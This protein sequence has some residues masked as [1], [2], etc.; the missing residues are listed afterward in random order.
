MN[1]TIY[2]FPIITFFPLN[3]CFFV[4]SLGSCSTT[5]SGRGTPITQTST[6]IAPLLPPFSWL[7]SPG[8]AGEED[9]EVP[10][11]QRKGCAQSADIDDTHE[12]MGL[13]IQQMP[14][15]VWDTYLYH[16]HKYWW[17]P[18]EPITFKNHNWLRLQLTDCAIF[19]DLA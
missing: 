13:L 10:F 16:L 3:N 12:C 15:S 17:Y 2:P 6:L 14:G 5:A 1:C 19:T 9:D 18:L 7:S 8:S 11:R 4:L